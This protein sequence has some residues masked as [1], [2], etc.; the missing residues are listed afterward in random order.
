MILPDCFLVSQSTNCKF[1]VLKKLTEVDNFW[2]HMRNN[3]FPPAQNLN[4]NH[5]CG[6]CH[7]FQ[8]LIISLLDNSL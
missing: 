3:N 4:G 8:E 2:L 7:H 6:H 5:G 1:P